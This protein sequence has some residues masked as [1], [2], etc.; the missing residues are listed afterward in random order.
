[1]KRLTSKI[2]VQEKENQELLE[3][4]HTEFKK[5]ED[6]KS[7]QQSDLQKLKETLKNKLQ[8]I[9]DLQKENKYL[10]EENEEFMQ[11]FKDM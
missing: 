1:M 9:S 3:E 4:F 11:K 6:S 8:K 5:M 7:S 2:A 10:H